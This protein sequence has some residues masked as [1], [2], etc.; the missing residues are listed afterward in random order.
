MEK[1][2]SYLLRYHKYKILIHL[3]YEL[4][5]YEKD[6]YEIN[7]DFEN[8][9]SYNYIEN[10][11]KLLF[12][13]IFNINENYLNYDTAE[14]NSMNTSFSSC[15]SDIINEEYLNSIDDDNFFNSLFFNNIDI[16]KHK[17]NDHCINEIYISDNYKS[18]HLH[19]NIKHQNINN[20]TENNQVDISH[21]EMCEKYTD[22]YNN[23]TKLSSKQ[24]N[25]EKEILPT[26]IENDN[27]Y[28]FCNITN[29]DHLLN[30]VFFNF[31]LNCNKNSKTIK[32][33]LKVEKQIL[34]IYY[35]SFSSTIIDMLLNNPNIHIPDIIIYFLF[36]NVEK[37]EDISSYFKNQSYTFD[38]IYSYI[39]QINNMDNKNILNTPTP[40]HTYE[41]FKQMHNK[42]LSQKFENEN[43]IDYI[44]NQTK[45]YN[46][47]YFNNTAIHLHKFI[48]DKKLDS[49]NNLN[50][51]IVE[52]KSIHI[53]KEDPY[54]LST[55]KYNFKLNKSN[56]LLNKFMSILNLQLEKHLHFKFCIDIFFLKNLKL[57]SLEASKPWIFYWCIHSIHLLYNTFEIEEKI[58]K[59][60]FDY[61]KKCV[62]LYLNKI[63]N[64]DGGFGGGLNQYTH[65]ATTYA[66]VCVF[67]YLH[68]EENNFLS[69][70]DKK[71]LHSYILKLKCKDGSFRVHINGEIDMRGTY[72]AISI[73]SMCH[74]LTNQVKKNVEKY[75][76][77]CQNYEGGFTSE[78]FQECH[79]GYSYCAL[80]T[81][82]IL[83]K[84]NK[85]N[86]KNLT[87]WL[88]SKQSNIEGAFMGRT[89]KLV[90]SCYSFWMGSIFFLINEIYMLKKILFNKDG[91]NNNNN[92][93]NMDDYIN[94]E[95]GNEIKDYS[96]SHELCQE[97]NINSN[98]Y[99]NNIKLNC[100]NKYLNKHFKYNNLNNNNPNNYLYEQKDVPTYHKIPNEETK[101]LNYQNVKNISKESNIMEDILFFENY[102][103]EYIKKNVLFNANYLKLYLHL[104]SQ[105]RK[106]GMKDKPKERIDY[107]HTCYALSGLSLVQNHLSLLDKNNSN[108]IQNKDIY[109]NLNKIHILYNITVDKVYN[110][111]NYFSPNV[112][113]NQNKINYRIGKGAYLYLKRLLRE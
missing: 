95:K 76:L 104:C 82:C 83:G 61:I 14:K 88:M 58:G 53:K 73:C 31:D 16:K 63:K 13:Y 50:F 64:N 110:S 57:I 77:S 28:I 112:P 86:L 101:F 79:G 23:E 105:N 67:I 44:N 25:I 52:F 42:E 85:I 41:D 68:D 69:F 100:L 66:A 94:I 60:T 107:Y 24:N 106:G 34:T 72:C 99:T 26:Y 49:K 12:N 37:I 80:A 91:I 18:E 81:L 1:N 92:N 43:N 70:L 38:T 96:K 9:T 98:K 27:K 102:K 74:I 40:L 111:Y 22:I 65:I 54:I 3:L 36:N 59:P 33:K 19:K 97:N 93:N 47:E 108:D 4:I 2:D 84:V 5:N 45:E 32:E 30:N 35:N 89:N 8:E 17:I 15:S 51:N 29:N 62:F 7:L 56:N 21:E 10:I 71:K 55:Y 6:K 113:L 39:K 78:K 11:I 109:N 20:L 90:D 46:N 87:H 75:I 103:N 48:N